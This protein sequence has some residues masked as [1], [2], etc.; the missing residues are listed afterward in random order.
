M[1]RPNPRASFLYARYDRTIDEAVVAAALHVS[2]KGFGLDNLELMDFLREMGEAYA[3]ENVRL[4]HFENDAE[5][6]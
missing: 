4:E 3:E 6:S 1:I 5:P 2:K